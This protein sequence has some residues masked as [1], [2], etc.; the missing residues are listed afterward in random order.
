MKLKYVILTLLVG[1]VFTSCS[2]DSDSNETKT[3]TPDEIN[4]FVWKAMNSWYYW[5]PNVADLSDNKIASTTT[6]ANFINGK[7]PDALFY[8]LLYQRGTVDRFSW[9]ENSNEVVY[10]SKIAEVEKSGGFSYGIYPKDASNIN[11]VA[12]INYI[13]PGSPAALAGLKRGDVITKLNGSPLTSSNYDQLNNT[14]LTLT[15]AASVQFIST[16]LVTTDKAGTVT[17]T[18]TEIDENPVA[19]Y[20]K[21]VYDSKNIGYLVYNGFKSDYNDELN[22]AFA[23]MKTDG[24]NELVLDLRYN[25]GGSLETAVAL[26]QM[27][28]GSFTNKPY[29]YLDFNNK[30]NSED[31]FENL[32]DKV[33]IFNLVDNE[34]TLQRNESINSLAL[35]KIYVLVSFQTASA[36][37]LTIQCLKKYI[38]VTTIGEETVGKFVGSNTL[39][40]SPA[41]NYASYAH[42]STKHKWQLQPITF[43]YYNKDKDVNPTKITP[44]YEVNPYLVFLNL[45][46]F[47]NVNDPCL[48]KALELITGQ[49]MRTTGKNTDTSLSFRIDNLA[50]FN[51]TNTAKGLYIEDFKSLKNK[52][53]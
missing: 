5:Q 30:H 22:A 20:E 51:P 47:G 32:S 31:G 9:I 45:V 4:N 17:V 2:K 28:N 3:T 10:A 8:S 1:L 40:D 19:Y 13:V 33:N 16:G 21:K 26:A 36:S 7:T 24:I 29:I 23:K 41:Y 44:D 42:R 18:K 50:A 37:E 35:T 12:L 39:Y 15:L 43:S 52:N 49:T 53:Q 11:M 38:N 14:Q 6:Y 34:P 25:G 27:I 46:E 48:K